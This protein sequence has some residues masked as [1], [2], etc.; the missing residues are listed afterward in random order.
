V[1]EL[2][3]RG[4]GIFAKGEDEETSFDQANWYSQTGVAEY[5]LEQYKA[6]V[7]EREGRFSLHA[8]L[9]DATYLENNKVRLSI[10]T[11]TADELLT[12]LV[13]IHSH[14]TDDSIR[15]QDGNRALSLHMACRSNAPVK[16]LRFLAEHDTA[17][18]YM[19]DSA[20]SLP[21][22]DACRSGASLEHIKFLPEKVGFGALCARDNQCQS[23]PSVQVVKYLLKSYPI[24][25][26]EKT[27]VCALPLMLACEL[28][29]S[30]DL[31]QELL[32]VHPVALA[33]R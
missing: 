14:G 7:W 16:V 18:L 31:L 25:V 20:G 10:G 2:V 9:G 22:H 3:Q 8:V 27:S 15:S 13:S 5:L 32:T 1:K 12:M 21:V 33:P 4:A 24:L 28:S 11:V 29:A 6:K 19:M 17:T 23:N 30:V 26:S